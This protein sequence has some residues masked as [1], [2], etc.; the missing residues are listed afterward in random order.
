[1]RTELKKKTWLNFFSRTT[2]RNIIVRTLIPLEMV[3]MHLRIWDSIQWRINYSDPTS[4]THFPKY[5]RER[6]RP[7]DLWRNPLR[8]AIATELFRPFAVQHTLLRPGIY[9]YVDESPGMFLKS[10]FRIN[11][12]NVRINNTGST[13]W[14][15][16]PSRIYRDWLKT[17]ASN[18]LLTLSTEIFISD[19]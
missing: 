9:T 6:P 5:H 3:L 18:G 7:P 4:Y 8:A 17:R 15:M 10:N 19:H 16:F 1:M 14:L 11:L 12:P 13:W 2:I